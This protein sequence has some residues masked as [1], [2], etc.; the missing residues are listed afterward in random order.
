MVTVVG[1]LLGILALVALGSFILILRHRLSF[2]IA[3]RN[4]RRGKWRTVLVVLGLLVGTTIVSGS[5]VIGD[6]VDAVNVHFTYQAL[7]FTDEAIYNQSPTLGYIPFPYSVYTAI[8]AGAA[9][10]PQIAGISPEIVGSVQILD[11]TTHVPQTGLNLIGGDGNQTSALGD[12]VADNGTSLAGPSSGKVFLDDLAASDVNASVGDTLVLYGHNPTTVTI[13]AI[14][15]DDTRGGFLFGPNVFASLATAQFVDNATGDVNFLAVTNVGSLTGGVA[16]SSSVAASLNAT[17]A[18]L[19]PSYGLAAHTILA[20]ALSTAETGGSSLTTLFIVLGLFSIIAGA[21]LIVGIFV[22]LAEERKGEMGMLRAIG[23]RRRQLIYTYY[24]E[25][26]LYSAGSAAAGT[27]LGVGVG[28]ALT[29][30]L[31]QL[32][33]SSNVTSSAILDSFTVS[34]Q[35]LVISYVVGFLLTVITVTVASWRVSRLNIVRAIRNIPE[36]APTLRTYTL[37][38]YLGILVAA[39]G[40]LL[41][42]GTYRG[43]SDISEPVIA[44]ALLLL[45][46]ALILSRLLP[47]RIAFSFLGVALLVWAGFAQLRDQLLGHDHSGSIFSVFVLGIILILGGILLFV[48][49]SQSIVAGIT[50]LGRG[51]ARRVSVVRVGLAY[52]GRR[53]FRTAINLTIFSLV[54]FTIVAVAAFGNSLQSNLDETITAQSG[55]Y[56]LFGASAVAIPNL[57]GQ[58]ANNSSLAP[59]YSAVVPFIAGGIAMNYSGAGTAFQY[60]LYAAPTGVPA[61]QNF[62]STNRY[63]FSSTLHGWSAATE[64]QELGSND[65]VAIVDGSFASNQ[66]AGGFG[67]SPA[68]VSVGQAIEVLDPDNGIHR[69]L[70]VIGILSETFVSG[71]F[72][73]PGTAAALGYTNESAY[74]FTVAPGIDPLHASQLTKAAFFP[75]GLVIFDFAQ[76]LQ[77]SVQGT[78][79]IIG[80]LEIFVALGLAVGIAAMGIV[81]LRAVSERRGEIGMLRATGFTR[82]MVLRSFL[83]EYSY[84]ALFGIGIGSSLAILLIWDTSQTAGGFL[85]FAIPWSN[86][87]TVILVAYAL[88]VLSILGPSL[89][90]SRLPP[91]E[92]IRYSE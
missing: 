17:I 59:L 14:V 36:P 86:I 81:A 12:F 68:P 83:L 48:F 18:T 41:F 65:S 38:A 88:T 71:V 35:T 33:G 47:N 45:G 11:R 6:T 27:I 62:Y 22:M 63:N 77:T 61:G 85:T 49:N 60:G 92:A 13:Q 58:I 2:R 75:E 30:A 64:F 53:P 79:A 16:A 66:F 84:V 73:S 23:L 54:L 31:A 82:G 8:A 7:G 44:G 40:A 43:T 26:L 4:A 1:L 24:F 39:I 52:P 21:M 25:G 67:P 28:Y 3:V 5:L 50:Y 19:H 91:A 51:K 70:T 15:H 29:L 46:A 55:G 69:N 78:E 37:F 80:L 56:T 34:T 87:A 20:T 90:A 32:F 89:K 42:L 72:V 76:I 74:L 10:N 57:P 9:G